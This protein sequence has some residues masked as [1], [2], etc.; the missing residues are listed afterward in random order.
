MNDVLATVTMAILGDY[1]FCKALDK[2]GKMHPGLNVSY[3][4]EI[5]LMY[6]FSYGEELYKRVRPEFLGSDAYTIFS[7]MMQR[8]PRKCFN[9]KLSMMVP[10][11]PTF[12]SPVKEKM[13]LQAKT[14]K[15]TT[16]RMSSQI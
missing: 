11:M 12:F 14:D 10:R 4:T 6:K 8:C 5:L 7:A 2:A 16:H 1:A 9:M 3:L 13:D 15:Q